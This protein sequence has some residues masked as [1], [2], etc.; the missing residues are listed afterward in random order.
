MR[1]KT[2]PSSFK[3]VDWITPAKPVQSIRGTR[4]QLQTQTQRHSA[5]Q[6]PHLALGASPA[7]PA[8]GLVGI[9]MPRSARAMPLSHP[10]GARTT[11]RAAKASPDAVFTTAPRP[12]RARPV[13]R[14][15]GLARRRN[16]GP[17]SARRLCA[18]ES[19]ATQRCDRDP[20]LAQVWV[21]LG[22]AEN[23]Y[24]W[25]TNSCCGRAAACPSSRTPRCNTNRP[26][27]RPPR[28]GPCPWTTSS[29][30]S[31]FEQQ[32]LRARAAVQQKVQSTTKRHD[33]RP[34][35]LASGICNV[36]P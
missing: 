33:A 28:R 17:R 34:Q 21:G 10:P 32:G 8:H 2:R 19:V 27:F 15:L 6:P 25:G 3:Y 24:A 22:R 1:M 20:E 13:T 23:G 18:D 9:S 11:W 36:Q 31:R 5:H 4:R 30:S 29:A 35:R 7:P 26:L 12:S 16:G 14:V